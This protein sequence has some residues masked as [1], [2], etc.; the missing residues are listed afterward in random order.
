MGTVRNLPRERPRTREAFVPDRTR[1]QS[2]TR[3]SHGCFRPLSLNTVAALI[4]FWLHRKDGGGSLIAGVEP[5]PAG[6][7]AIMAVAK[8]TAGMSVAC[9]S[10]W[11]RVA[12]ADFRVHYLRLRVG[13]RRG[14]WW[15]RLFGSRLSPDDGRGEHVRANRLSHRLAPPSD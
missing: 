15:P 11:T 12:H 2:P 10:S 8:L 1:T 9:R 5:I 13:A 6:I 4:R 14:S 7:L 3:K